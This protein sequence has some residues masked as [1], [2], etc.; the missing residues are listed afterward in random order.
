MSRMN[1]ARFSIA[2]AAL[3][4]VLPGVAFAGATGGGSEADYDFNNDTKSDVLLNKFV[5]PN[6]GLLQTLII[7]GT[8]Q[9]DSGFPTILPVEYEVSG[10]G[11]FSG[12]GQADILSRK[13]IA[14]NLGLLRVQTLDAAGTLVTGSVF[15]TLVDPAYTLIGIGDL[16]GNGK[17]DLAYA[18][19]TE[20]NIGLIRV[21]LFSDAGD[22]TIMGTGFPGAVSAG[23][24]GVGLSDVDGDGLADIVT[25]KTV[26]PNLGLVRAFLTAPGGITV[27]SSTFP[28]ITPP[29]YQLSGVV[30]LDNGAGLATADFAFEKIAAPNV[31]LIQAQYTAPGGAAIL[32]SP[33]F[34]VLLV[35]P[36]T[37][38]SLGDFDG[39][40]QTDLGARNPVSGVMRNYILDATGQTS[41]LNG[42]PS[43]PATTYEVVENRP[44][45]P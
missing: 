22:R 18:K 25:I 29:T 38:S 19:T 20:P 6:I 1:F 33:A 44:V 2:L 31:G 15:P 9:I 27:S 39:M 26:V 3:L 4:F 34:P 5:A 21:Y 28:T 40:N 37:I 12:T 45:L 32:G 36:F 11:N 24:A 23:N 14:P 8:A 10:A 13:V 35:T 30:P 43:A 41:S 7:D 42:F 17:D 16:D